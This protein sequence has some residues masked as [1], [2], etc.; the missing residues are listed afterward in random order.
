MKVK[1]LEDRAGGRM[2]SWVVDLFVCLSV[3]RL[4]SQLADMM[5]AKL[6]EALRCVF[7]NWQSRSRCIE[8]ISWL[9]EQQV[10]STP[11]AQR[12]D[13]KQDLLLFA[14]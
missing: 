4:Q 12:G 7:H 13:D 3:G 10:V 9:L 8:A 1:P 14:S 5:R 6:N 2:Q 11:F